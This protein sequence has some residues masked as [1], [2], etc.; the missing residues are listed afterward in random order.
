MSQLLSAQGTLV[1]LVHHLRILLS[2][3][4]LQPAARRFAVSDDPSSDD[5]YKI[6]G[7]PGPN[8]K[9]FLLSG[10]T[11]AFAVDTEDPF[12]I[13]TTGS[14]ESYVVDGMNYYDDFGPTHST[15]TDANAGITRG[16]LY[17]TIPPETSAQFKYQNV[18]NPAMFGTIQVKSLYNISPI[19]P[20]P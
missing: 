3:L 8:P 20:L 6:S 5:Q 9:L 1:P 13:T 10:L 7:F 4:E 19:E 2:R 11:Y 15:G 14:S 18:T 17:W 16:T 12:V